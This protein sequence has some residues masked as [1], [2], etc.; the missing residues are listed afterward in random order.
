IIADEGATTTNE[1][2][3]AT[4]SIEIVSS[5]ISE[6]DVAAESTTI[7]ESIDENTGGEVLGVS[8]GDDATTTIVAATSTMATSTATS[9]EIADDIDPADG[10]L[11]VRYSLDGANWFNLEQVN[12]D[13]WPDFTVSLPIT[14]WEEVENLQ[15][16]ITEVAG[17]EDR[18]EVVYFDGAIIE[19][20]FDLPTF[21][22][23]VLPDV[24][25]SKTIES[26]ADTLNVFTGNDDQVEVTEESVS[27]K[28][29]V[30]EPVILTREAKQ[31]CKVLPFTGAVKRGGE[32]E[33]TLTL[34]PSG[35]AISSA[36][37]PGAMPKG[38]NVRFGA[39]SIGNEMQEVPLYIFADKDARQGSF[40]VS[41]LY[42][43]SY[44]D[45]YV[46]ITS[47]KFNPVIE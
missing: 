38:L 22:G 37:N 44:G 17:T 10:F 4:T 33:H 8:S 27:E 31:R 45:G 46:S 21:L 15:I 34:W 6:A 42:K 41:V 1:D 16:S 18:A 30:E 2:A 11:L 39:D 12:R 19:V 36:L 25:V 43:E 20:H 47:C 24:P 29:S 23:D 3:L 5:T 28:I 13:N 32:V 9:T 14:S 7:K 26:L 40:N 35:E